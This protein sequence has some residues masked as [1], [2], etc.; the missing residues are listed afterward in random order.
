MHGVAKLNI[1]GRIQ[2]VSIWVMTKKAEKI[3]G[4]WRTQ[5]LVRCT[6]EGNQPLADR[7]IVILRD[8]RVQAIRKAKT[9][10]RGLFSCTLDLPGPGEYFVAAMIEGTDLQAGEWVPVPAEEARSQLTPNDISIVKRGV[11][12][13]WQLIITVLHR[14]GAAATPVPGAVVTVCDERGKKSLHLTND[15]GTTE[16][17]IPT[18]TSRDLSV[19]ITV[20]G[21]DV[22]SR[23]SLVGLPSKTAP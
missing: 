18:F 20:D 17:K 16:C 22:V 14:D 12:G 5:I 13:R 2:Q 23:L 6:R 10:T 21:S 7:P 19:I 3:D 11:P 1:G 9:D 8:N 15:R 4:R